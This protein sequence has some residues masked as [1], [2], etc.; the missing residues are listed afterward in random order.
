MHKEKF[1][2]ILIIFIYSFIY[3]KDTYQIIDSGDDYYFVWPHN[4]SFF[5][6]DSFVLRDKKQLLLFDNKGKFIRNLLTVGEGPGEVQGSFYYTIDR[7]KDTVYLYDIYREKLLEKR[8][9]GSLVQERKI[10]LDC[11]GF[12]GMDIKGKILTL[13]ELPL[14]GSIK[15]N[16]EI[17]LFYNIQAINSKKKLQIKVKHFYKS[18]YDFFALAQLH[19]D[20]TKDKLIINNKCDYD[21]NIYNINNFQLI[22][23]I[24]EPQRG[25][26]VNY[27]N[28]QKIN[29]LLGGDI[30]LVCLNLKEKK[31]LTFDEFSL[32]GKYLSTFKINKKYYPLA[33]RKGLIYLI[34]NDEETLEIKLRICDY[35]KFKL[36][37]QSL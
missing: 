25:Y 35:Q 13:K 27:K 16:S 21:I 11:D 10:N 28:R 15:K 26:R 12:L 32:N 1:L 20:T 17:N 24:K 9:D 4:L 22:S 2:F 31:T 3:A 19:I 14:K 5:K 6:D 18:Q 8:K 23:S 33:V 30:L 37:C 29:F 34:E 36:N 7:N